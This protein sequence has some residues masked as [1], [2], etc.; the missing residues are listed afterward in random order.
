MSA[1]Q[2]QQRSDDG[3][4]PHIIQVILNA[5]DLQLVTVPV[6]TDIPSPLDVVD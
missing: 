5:P 1:L 4:N 3:P 2:A 6:V